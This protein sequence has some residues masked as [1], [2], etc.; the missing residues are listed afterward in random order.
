MKKI[1]TFLCAAA[2]VACGKDDKGG[3]NPTPTP[4]YDNLSV[5]TMP[6][7]RPFCFF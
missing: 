5:A 6:S 1:L 7:P 3:E 4:H 2:L